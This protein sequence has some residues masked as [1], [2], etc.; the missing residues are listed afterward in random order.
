MILCCRYFRVFCYSYQQPPRSTRSVTLFPYSPLFRSVAGEYVAGPLQAHPVRRGAAAVGG[1]AR[2]GGAAGL[3]PVL[4][5]GAVAGADQ[6]EGVPRSEEHKSELQ[7]LIRISD[8]VFCLK[9]KKKMKTLLSNT[10]A[11]D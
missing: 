10:G 8:A 3:G 1:A 11:A 4:E 6:H 5:V 9:K 2:C 7:P